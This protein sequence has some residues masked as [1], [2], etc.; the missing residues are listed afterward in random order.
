MTEKDVIVSASKLSRAFPMQDGELQ[1]LNEVDLELAR[2]HA[3]AVT[4]ESGSG[5]STLLYI[6]GTLDQP[7]SGDVTLL[8]VNPFQMSKD[9]Q[10][11]FRNRNI[12]FVFQDHHLLPQC[13]VLE[14]VILPSLALKKKDS[15]AEDRAKNLLEHV[16]LADRM[17]HRPTQISG[18]E[19]QRVAVCRALINQPKILLADEPTGNLDQKTSET[20]GKLLLEMS[21]EQKTVLLCVTHSLI[22]AKKFPEHYALQNGKLKKV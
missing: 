20:V 19:R 4:G 3:V 7:S 9:A 13:T 22:L 11:E 12:G 8:S 2:G 6:L 1:V 17:K 21:E 18:G 16:G 14:N 10:A 5:K 15:S